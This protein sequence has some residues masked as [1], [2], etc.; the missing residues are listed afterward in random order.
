MATLEEIAPPFVE[1][2]HR[3]VWA[4]VATV[5]ALGRP[6]S[7]VLHPIWEWDGAALVGWVATTPSPKLGHLERSGHASVN[8]WQANHDTCLAECRAE[9]IRDEAGRTEVWERFAAAPEPIGYDPGGIGMPGWTAPTAPGFVAL[10]LSPWRLR[11]MPGTVM[12]EQRG[13]LLTWSE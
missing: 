9:V 4:S 6:R 2:A 8:Y 10:R 12:L 1:M 7:R 3:I 11:L 13:E 5:D